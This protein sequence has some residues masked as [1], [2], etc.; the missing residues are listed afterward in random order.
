[1]AN[2]WSESAS[3][4]LEG[5]LLNLTVAVNRNA[6]HTHRDHLDPADWSD[7]NVS[8]LRK[9]I[10]VAGKELCIRAWVPYPGNGGACL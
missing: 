2:S 6:E 8:R 4:S 10:V 3:P 1:M 5:Q 9:A 7:G